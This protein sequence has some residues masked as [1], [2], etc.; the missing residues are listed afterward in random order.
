MKTNEGLIRAVGVR[1]LTAGMM[2]YMIGAGIFVLPALVAAQVGA[3]APIVYVVCAIAMGLIVMCFADAGSRVSLSGGTY[4]YAGTAFGPFV[5]FIVAVTLWFG[6]SVL[7]AAAVVSVFIDTLATL[8]PA[9]AAPGVRTLILALIYTLFAAINIRGVKMGSGVVQ[10]VTLAKLAPLFAL[11]A[12]GLFAISLPNLDWPGMPP[13][14]TIARASVVLIFAFLGIETA[15]NISGEV[16]DP[17]RTVPRAI[18]ATIVLVTLIYMA[19]QIVSQGVLGPELA[20]NTKAPLAETARRVLGSGGEKLVLIGTAI[21]TFGYAAGDML[22]SPRGLYAMGRDRLVPGLIGSVSDKF[23][24]PYV[25]I[26]IHAGFCFGFAATGSFEGL[27]VLATLSTLIVYLVCCAA[28]IRLRQLD[29]RADGAVPFSVPGGPI[30][31][32]IAC[33]VVVWLMTSSTRQEFIAISVMLGVEVLLYLVMRFHKS[34]VPA[35]SQ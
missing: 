5:G 23:H 34:A 27:I 24:T 29:V 11:I 3:A 17:A 2:N 10:V 1:G 26:L 30:I 7:A 13:L 6:S 31:P 12:F 16:K 28:T 33:I 9:T 4:A 19:L 20:A 22:A 25:A 35:S 14:S 15:L 21:S 8:V 18:L 32:V